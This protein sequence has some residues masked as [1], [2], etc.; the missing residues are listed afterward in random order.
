MGIF[1]K[2]KKDVDS[3]YERRMSLAVNDYWR[4]AQLIKKKDLSISERAKNVL[5]KLFC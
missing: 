5:C 2:T 1:N 4:L 3:Y